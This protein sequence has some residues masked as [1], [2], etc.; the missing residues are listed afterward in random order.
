MGRKNVSYNMFSL[1][2]VSPILWRR[3]DSSQIA[4]E[5]EATKVR[6]FILL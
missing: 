4:T 6:Q 1:I 2:S 3:G 5:V